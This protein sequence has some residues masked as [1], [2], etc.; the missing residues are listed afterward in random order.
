MKKRI[1]ALFLFCAIALGTGALPSFAATIPIVDSSKMDLT[2]INAIEASRGIPIGTVI[3][4]SSPGNPDDADKWLEC[5][6]RSTAGYPELAAIVGAKTPDYRDQFLRGGDTGQVGQVAADSTR[7]HAHQMDQH[8][9]T[10]SGTADKQSYNSPAAGGGGGT[11]T[12]APA[13]SARY[14]YICHEIW[15]EGSMIIDTNTAPYNYRGYLIANV[16]PG[17]YCAETHMGSI[18]GSGNFLSENTLVGGGASVTAYTSG[19]S[20][21]G[22]TDQGGPTSTYAYGDA[23]TAPQHTRVRYLIRALP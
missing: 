11:F 20:I 13:A 17:N 14:S 1:T 2:A 21:T 4:W 19:G 9:H 3:V 12:R 7:S 23:E 10:V 16:C 18:Y 5:D 6:G 15:G 22:I 8:S